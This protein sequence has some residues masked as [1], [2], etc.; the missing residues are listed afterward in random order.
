[1]KK[2]NEGQVRQ[3]DVLLVRI[4]EAAE[5]SAAAQPLVL[6]EGEA[7]G[8]KHQFMAESR[9]SFLGREPGRKQLA[10]GAPSALRH[11]E[12]SPTTVLPGIYDLPH[13][14]EWTDANEPRVVAD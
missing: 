11:E 10:V 9:V 3:G 8:H 12:H 4:G 14:V 6:R 13:Q 1:M 7:T 5:V 2:L